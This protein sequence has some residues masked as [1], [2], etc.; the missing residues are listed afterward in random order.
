MEPYVVST[1]PIW[2]ETG[3]DHWCGLTSVDAVDFWCVVDDHYRVNPTKS[4]MLIPTWEAYES[5]CKWTPWK[6]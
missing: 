3:I 6:R 4:W 1:R 2:D 5:A